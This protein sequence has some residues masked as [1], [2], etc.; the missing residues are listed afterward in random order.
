MIERLDWFIKL[1]W[2]AV[3]G[4]FITI[5]LASR[6]F[7][8]RL[9]LVPLVTISSLIA[10]YN[11]VFLF[12]KKTLLKDNRLGEVLKKANRF[13]NIQ[14]SVD[15][16]ALTL[17]IY[18]SGG[19]ENPFVFYFLFHMIVASII[20]TRRA[21]YLQATLATMLFGSLAALE[22]YGL[23][24][25]ICLDGF[26][27]EGLCRDKIYVLAIFFVFASTIYISVAMATSISNRL[28]QRQQEL[29]KVNLKLIEQYRLKSK[30]VSH[31]LR[32]AHDIRKDLSAIQGCLKLISAGFVGSVEEKQ[33]RLIERA[34]RRTSAL[35]DF[36]EDVLSLARLRS[37]QPPETK[38]TSL[39]KTIREALESLPIRPEN[40]GVRLILE[41][42]ENLPETRI[43][44]VQ[45]KEVMINL[46]TNAV[47]YTPPGGEIR[48]AAT[49]ETHR[50]K[51]AVSD[52]GIG[53]K[54]EDKEQIFNEFYRS[55]GAKK[56]DL[57]GKGLG[58]AIVRQI[59]LSYGGEIWVESAGDGRGSAFFFTLPQY[60]G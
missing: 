31:V 1:R 26:A 32:V 8:L 52:T 59:I 23:I 16:F 39:A 54:P 48:V 51:V 4:V 6:V 22:Y 34:E 42:P 5:F 28:R 13:A 27:R 47:K 30:Y 40:K 58:L 29:A 50:V 3:L 57:D 37:G 2:V 45:I 11:F 60:Q 44:E 38:R 20:L 53:V 56:I 46:L 25:S 10:G 14:I 55:D 18:F 49:A 19:V 7:G 36:V 43:N 35:F 21:T 17:L 9:H 12:Y 33:G 15:L 24:P 41:L